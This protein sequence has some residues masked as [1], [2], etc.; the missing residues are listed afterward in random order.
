MRCEGV[1]ATWTH[2]TPAIAL[3]VAGMIV[4]LATGIF[5]V[6]PARPS[7]HSTQN[8]STSDTNLHAHTLHGAPHIPQ[9][10]RLTFRE[11]I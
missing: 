1:E 4:L 6:T 2:F 9:C 7:P 11:K 3:S 10:W 8:V 5:G